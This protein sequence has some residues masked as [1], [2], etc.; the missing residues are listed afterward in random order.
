VKEKRE[1]RLYGMLIALLLFALLLTAVLWDR[2]RF[3]VPPTSG[4]DG[5]PS[6]VLT[7][8]PTV[9]PLPQTANYPREMRYNEATAA[10]RDEIV[11]RFVSDGVEGMAAIRETLADYQRLDRGMAALWAQILDYWA[12]LNTDLHLYYDELPDGLPTDDRLCLVVLGYALESN[13]GMAEELVQRC[14][15]A[16]AGAEK[17]PNA[18]VLVTGGPTAF[19]SGNTEA[20]CMAAWLAAHGVAKERLIIEDQALTTAQNA[21]YGAKLLSRFP[22]VDSLAII[23]SDYHIAVG[24]LMFEAEALAEEY[25]RGEKPFSVVANAACAYPTKAGTQGISVQ[26]TFLRSLMNPT[27]RYQ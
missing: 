9:T 25:E 5:E 3:S 24:S 16:L 8:V 17:Y 20:G 18:Y 13:G 2:G 26:S 21:F 1:K 15:V 22:Q 11:R 7:P 23:T 27:A 19:M 4:W 12:A 10:L 14:T 6:P